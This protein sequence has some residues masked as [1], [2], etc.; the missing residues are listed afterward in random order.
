MLRFALRI[1]LMFSSSCIVFAQTGGEITGEVTDPSGAI[2]P[3]VSV[4]ATNTDTNVARST[5]TNS[6]GLYSFPDLTPGK[7]QV[8]AVSK[9][10]ETT[11][12]LDRGISELVRAAKLIEFQNPFA[13]V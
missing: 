11:I 2:M 13:N 4:T 3:A 12:D 10:F 7:Y 9:G 6:A 8:K 1:A 5:V